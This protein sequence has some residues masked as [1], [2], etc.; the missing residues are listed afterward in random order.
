MEYSRN[1]IAFRIFSSDYD[2]INSTLS[3]LIKEN[4]I[5]P[6]NTDVIID[7]QKIAGNKEE[8]GMILSSIL[9]EIPKSFNFR[10]IIISS[11]SFPDDFSSIQTNSSN[12]FP[13]DEE[14]IHERSLALSDRLG[15][16]Y[17]YSDYGPASL[18]VIEFVPGMSPAFKIKYS[19]K[20]SYVCYKGMSGKKQGMN[21]DN[22]QP[23][24]ADLVNSGSY[25]G[26]DFSFGDAYID[27]VYTRT[28]QSAGNP[29]TWVQVAQNHHIELI[30]SL[31]SN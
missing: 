30:I 18:E 27:S 14:Y 6:Q 1:G 31:L 8:K 29:T 28:T 13:R 19:T 10:A 15:F 20:S 22:V 4:I 25:Y 11:D 24:C 23:L 21:I 3:Q 2:R 9:L 26:K 5:T 17:I 16:N 12:T 7:L